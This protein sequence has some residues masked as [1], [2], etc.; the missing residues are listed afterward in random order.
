[1]GG[2]MNIQQHN[3]PQAQQNSANAMTPQSQS[4]QNGILAPPTT[5]QSFAG[6]HVPPLDRLRFQ[7]S[8]RHFCMTKKL[9]INQAALNIRGKQVDL[10]ALHDEVLKLRATDRRVSSTSSNS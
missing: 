2:H 7:S 8:H 9:T 10:H 5:L 3:F 6:T 4:N 1:M